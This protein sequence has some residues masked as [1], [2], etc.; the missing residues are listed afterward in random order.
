MKNNT[1]QFGGI[2]IDSGASKFSYG[3]KLYIRYYSHTYSESLILQIT[4]VFGGVG[5]R[6]FLSPGR[7][8]VKIPIVNHYF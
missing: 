4:T 6:Q 2:I 8:L 5:H 7:V 3:L 1:S